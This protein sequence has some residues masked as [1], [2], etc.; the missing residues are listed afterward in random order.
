MSAVNGSECHSLAIP[1]FS[2][3][4]SRDLCTL[5]FLIEPCPDTLTPLPLLRYFFPLPISPGAL[6]G[7]A[8]LPPPPPAPKPMPAPVS[9]AYAYRCFFSAGL[10]IWKE[11]ISVSS[12]LIIAPALSNS[13][14]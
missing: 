13:P 6:G 11:H 10:R 14:Q 2:R 1:S 7:V 3:V 4:T 8:G 9:P 5:S 12:T